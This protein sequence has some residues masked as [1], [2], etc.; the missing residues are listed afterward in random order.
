M[1]KSLLLLCMISPRL[2]VSQIRIKFQR[3]KIY[4]GLL[5]ENDEK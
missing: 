1:Y 5:I 2:G 3:D 4:N